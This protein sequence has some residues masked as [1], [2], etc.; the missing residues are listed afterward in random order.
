MRKPVLI[1]PGIFLLLAGLFLFSCG[2]FRAIEKSQ[3]WRVKYEAAINYYQEEEY[4]KAS[5]LFEQILPIVR[6]MPE[7]EKV[8]FYYAYSQYNLGMYTLAAHH[9]KTFYET[10]GRSEFAEEANYMY[11]YSLYADSPA[12]NLDQTNSQQAIIAMQAFL[13]RYPGSE[14]VDEAAKVVNDIQE[15]LERKGYENAK[16]YYKLENYN[17]AVVAFESFSNNFPDSEYNE[18]IAYLRFIA[19]YQYALKSIYSRQLE[20]FREANRFYLDFLD[21]Y[22]NSKFLQDAEKQYRNSLEKVSDLA[23]L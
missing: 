20:R 22:P 14:L 11:A 17:A 4:Y 23:Q 2:K 16:Q 15:K 10:Y 8:Q 9:F 21:K 19:Q 5:V 6:G 12:Y 3:D 13:N 18:E 7:G 1:T